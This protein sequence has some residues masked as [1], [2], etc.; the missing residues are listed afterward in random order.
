M[1][2]IKTSRIPLFDKD[3]L[4][5]YLSNQSA[6]GIIFLDFMPDDETNSYKHKLVFEKGEKKRLF[7][8]VDIF[9]NRENQNSGEYLSLCESTGWKYVAKKEN[10]YVFYTEK[11]DLIPLQTD[12][13][14]EAELMK[15]VKLSFVKNS[16]LTLY[17]FYMIIVFEMI[18]IN[19]FLDSPL[20][21]YCF[22]FTSFGFLCSLI[23]CSILL[24]TKLSVFF[25]Y[26]K[27]KT[28][29]MNRIQPKRR[30]SKKIIRRKRAADI[31]TGVLLLVTV[32]SIFDFSVEKEFL[33]TIPNDAGMIKINE[34]NIITKEEYSRTHESV[35][36]YSEHCLQVHSVKDKFGKNYD[37]TIFSGTKY[38]FA[39]TLIAYDVYHRQKGIYRDCPFTDFTEEECER[40][41]IS[42]GKYCY[43]EDDDT[44][45]IIFRDKKIYY[46]LYITGFGTY[47]DTIGE[48]ISER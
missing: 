27:I 45:N 26:R 4:Q 14:T 13:E 23:A 36:A 21:F 37:K 42:E 47:K 7:Y 35:F 3:M 39:F 43:S 25:R 8:C 33:R 29:L 31:L 9:G 38:S 46:E 48:I 11:D 41:R 17:L 15:T 44:L 12:S 24:I 22:T 10:I 20:S 16:I 6:R 30:N 18:S 34:S 19:Y 1:K 5:Q 40:L 28:D 32:L 2:I